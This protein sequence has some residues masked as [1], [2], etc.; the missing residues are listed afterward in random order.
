MDCIEFEGCRVGGYGQTHKG[1]AHRV[2]WE[3]LNGP[4]P[5]GHDIHHTCENRACIEPT[6]LKL[7]TRRAHL[8]MHNLGRRKCDHGE[9][10]RYFYAS[11]R[12]SYCRACKNAA[13]RAR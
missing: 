2:A 1:Y 13:R 7:M 4:I 6:H 12:N 8:R 5:E 3:S 10:A 9:E 11:G